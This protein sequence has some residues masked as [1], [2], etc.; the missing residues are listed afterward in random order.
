MKPVLLDLFCGV[1]GASEG[2]Y[3]AGFDVV[4]VDIEPQ[5]DYRYKFR[6]GDALALLPDLIEE[7]NPVAVAGSPPCQAK[8][9]LTT[10]TNQGKFTYP[11]LIPQ[12][13]ALFEASGLPYVIENVNGAPIRKDVTLCGEMF[14]LGVIRHRH[15]ELGGWSMPKPVHVPHRGRVAGMRT[16]RVVRGSVLRCVR[17][18][19]RQGHPRAV[20]RGDGDRLDV[21]SQVDCGG[22]SA[23]I[24]AVHRRAVARAGPPAGAG[25]IA[26]LGAEK[27]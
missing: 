15:F 4:G 26:R 14:G 19:W 17:R 12:T 23:C 24:H 9:T 3:R 7:F 25:G 18:G 2:Y 20:A 16:R 6:Q 5:S 11:Q 8:C 22:D 10:G 13:R 1:G 27:G 21:E